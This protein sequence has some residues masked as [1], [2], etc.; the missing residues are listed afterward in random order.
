MHES[1]APAT[2]E[3]PAPADARRRLDRLIGKREDRLA[4]SRRLA[5]RFHELNGYLATADQVTDALQQLSQQLFQQLLSVVQE[6][7][8]IALQEI[9]EQPLQLRAQ[10]DF[11]RQ[12]ATVEFWI[13]RNGNQEDILKG[14]GGSVA[15]V[16][17][18]GLRMFAL[19]TLDSTQHR[20]FLVLDEQDCWLRPDLV[21][22]LVKIV[23]EA[24]QALGFQVLMISHHDVSLFERYA[25]R[26]Y[27]FG[28][29]AEGEV[30]VRQLSLSAHE[31]DTEE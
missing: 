7:L 12:M 17:S 14:Q 6:K 22:R 11:K 28:L 19:T 13:E 5:S 8:S 29:N 10:A 20:R 16:L 18:V 1:L 2:P 9:L 30:Q 3:L 21:P 31:P 26:I 15:N 27:Q 4:A 25:D 23:H 24:S